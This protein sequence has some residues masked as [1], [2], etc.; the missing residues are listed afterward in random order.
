MRSD[1]ERQFRRNLKELRES[2][3]LS[4]ADVAE[5]MRNYGFAFHPQTV[6]KIETGDREVKL[7][8]GL[9]LAVLFDVSVYELTREPG[10]EELEALL[11]QANEV[12]QRAAMYESM[13]DATKKEY[14]AIRRRLIEL[15]RAQGNIPGIT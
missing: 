11:A 2:K 7:A 14:D 4:Q 15:E 13:L 3:G 12:A 10:Q 6:Q 8:E 1:L 9:A 5:A